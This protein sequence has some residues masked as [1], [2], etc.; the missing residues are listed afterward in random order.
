MCRHER[1]AVFQ[2]APNLTRGAQALVVLQ[3]VQSEQARGRIERTLRRIVDVALMQADAFS[4]GPERPARLLQH[5]RGRIDAVEG[6]TRLC[7]G[8][9]LQLQSAS[10][11]QD[12]HPGILGSSLRQKQGGHSV[13]VGEARH[14][15]RRTFGIARNGFRVREGRQQLAH[16]NVSLRMHGL[17][18]MGSAA[19]FQT[20][21]IDC[22]HASCHL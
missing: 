19:A 15:P 22:W 7:V 1:R 5:L 10:G 20:P 9:R 14:E 2:A 8:K 16:G 6:P 18:L 17:Q 4:A 12:E 3:E 11:P 13:Q 21:V